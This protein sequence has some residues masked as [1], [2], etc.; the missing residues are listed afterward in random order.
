MYSPGLTETA[1][2]LQKEADLPRSTSTPY[3]HPSSPHIYSTP[4]SVCIIMSAV[5]Q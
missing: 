2:V 4:R 1:A 5:Y 3:T